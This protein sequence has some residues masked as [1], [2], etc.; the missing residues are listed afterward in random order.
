MISFTLRTCTTLTLIT[1]YVA[2]IGISD[3]CG[4]VEHLY[5]CAQG[6][7]LYLAPFNWLVPEFTSAH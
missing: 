7:A 1:H 6:P 3:L 5:A 2:Y 4:E